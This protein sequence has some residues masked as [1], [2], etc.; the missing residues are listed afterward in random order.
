MS[1]EREKKKS[2]EKKLKNILFFSSQPDSAHCLAPPELTNI[3]SGCPPGRSSS[4]SR[5]G[6]SCFFF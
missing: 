5:R 3:Y 6:A 2:S 4:R 1:F